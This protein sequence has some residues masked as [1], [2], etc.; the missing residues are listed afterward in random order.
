MTLIVMCLFCFDLTDLC[1]YECMDSPY[2][3][4]CNL[5]VQN[6][7]CSNHYYAKFCCKS[8]LQNNQLDM[9][10]VKEVI[11]GPDNRSYNVLNEGSRICLFE[12]TL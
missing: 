9:D 6:Q 12:N 8:C 5:I 11:I 10:K 1:K 7:F 3:A 2:F 4:D